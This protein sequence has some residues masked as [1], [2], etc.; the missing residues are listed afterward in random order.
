MNET[1]PPPEGYELVKLTPGDCAPE[2]CLVFASEDKGWERNYWIAKN[3]WFYAVKKDEEAYDTSRFQRD[4]VVRPGDTFLDVPTVTNGPT[5]P[6]T[7]VLYTGPKQW[8][9]LPEGSLFWTADRGWYGQSDIPV[10][11]VPGDKNHYAIPL[12]VSLPPKSHDPKGDAGALKAPLWLLPPSALEAASWVHKLGAEKYGTANWR[13]NKVCASTYISAMMRHLNQWRDG[14]DND[15]E[16]GVSHLAHTI[17][18][19]NILID[20]AHC[21]TLIDDRAKL[22]V[23]K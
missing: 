11:A 8:Q 2:G 18:S 16:S 20:A 15:Q 1:T 23:T 7:H 13:D 22:P 5:P 19:A 12:N 6:P 9:K 3:D 17:A 21:G 4:N 14:E 10:T